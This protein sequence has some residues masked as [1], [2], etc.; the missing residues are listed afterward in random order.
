[1]FLLAAFPINIQRQYDSLNAGTSSDF[2]YG[3]SLG[4]NTNLVVDP[5]GNVTF[6]LS[7]QRRT[8]NLTP[9]M[10][11]CSPLLGCLF[12]YYWPVYTPEPGLHGTLPDSGMG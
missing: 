11:G 7:G 12:P 1:M 10:T 5:A 4:I 8:F 2:G 6:T 3:W 9:Q